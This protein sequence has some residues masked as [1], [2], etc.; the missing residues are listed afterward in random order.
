MK[1]QQYNFKKMSVTEGLAQSQVKSFAQDITGSLWIATNGGGISIFNGRN[2]ESF[3]EA[4]GLSGN[5]ITALCS[6]FGSK[7]YAASKG[8]VD[9]IEGRKL[10]KRIENDA[11]GTV[12]N[13]SPIGS[14]SLVLACD[15]GVYLLSGDELKL[16][17]DINAR[18][19]SVMKLS[20]GN[21]LIG[22]EKGLLCLENDSTY[23]LKAI[24]AVEVRSIK[25]DSVGDV[26]VGTYARG[27]IVL[28]STLTIATKETRVPYDAVVTDIHISDS[29]GIW[30]ATLESGLYLLQHTKFDHFTVHEGLPNNSINCIYEDNES[31]IWL[32]SSGGGMSRYDGAMFV[33][34]NEKDGLI[35]D[36]VYSIL[37]DYEGKKWFGTFAG[38]VSRMDSMGVYVFSEIERFTD[39]KVKCIYQSP[40]STIWF[41]TEGDGLFR[42]RANEFEHVPLAAKWIKSIVRSDDST[43][44][45]AS[46]DFGVI[47]YK[48]SQQDIFNESRGLPSTRIADLAIDESGVLWA[49]TEKGLAYLNSGDSGFSIIPEFKGISI[50]S[51]VSIGHG[52]LCVGTSGKGVFLRD[53][54]ESLHITSQNG[55]ASNICYFVHQDKKKQLWVGSE[56]GIDRLELGK[57][58]RLKAVRHYGLEQGF[59]GL[60]TCKNAVFEEFNGKIW[61]GTVNGVT[62]YSPGLDLI[63]QSVPKLSFKGLDL[64]YEPIQ[65]FDNQ[66]EYDQWSNMPENLVLTHL[67]NHLTFS[68]TGVAMRNAA[69]IK[70]QW[71]LEGFEDEWSPLSKNRSVTY[72]NI[73]PGAYIFKVKALNENGQWTKGDLTYKFIIE[74]PYWQ[75]WWFVL[76][77]SIVLVTVIWMLIRLAVTRANKR[78]EIQKKSLEMERRALE[79]EQKALRLQMNPHFLFNCLNT[80]KAFI[81]ENKSRQA[82]FQL[83]KFAKLMRLML[84]NSRASKVLIQSEV[85]ALK[86]YLELEQLSHEGKFNFEVDVSEEFNDGD[87]YIPPMIVQPFVENAIIHGVLPAQ[88]TGLISISFKLLSDNVICE[89]EDNG[90]G[91]SKSRE[92]QQHSLQ[93]HKSAGIQVTQ[94]RLNVLRHQE[95]GVLIDI[96]IIDKF[97]SQGDSQGTCVTIRLPIMRPDDINK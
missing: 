40:D 45:I 49:A 91:R 5:F 88:Y 25:R 3:T 2:F 43:L 54:N 1:A 96:N 33:H 53:K 9:V 65:S 70:Y 13:M 73:P 67:N 51:V 76:T 84:D 44:W 24:P 38:G 87:F 69:L 37:I 58:G 83:A 15:G 71:K 60:E 59:T 20:K 62:C 72:S 63:S 30:L 8:G 17:V 82:K 34:Y 68:F 6:P 81:S 48:D 55:L 11:C 35:G 41:G 16:L 92:M 57:N 78:N 39:Q 19:F 42:F 90:I 21:Y 66:F 64:F 80:I 77:L 27:V 56:K 89:I 94:E 93:K 28:D 4:D 46:A 79:L 18:C 26:W 22:T 85:E 10:V 14:D 97:N 47:A 7:I 50:A 95:K 61:F 52:K 36:G 29:G 74:A 31:N 12:H 23:F 75:S 86:S 32:G